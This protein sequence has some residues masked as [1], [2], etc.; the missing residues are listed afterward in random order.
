[1]EKT[2]SILIKNIDGSFNVFEYATYYRI[3]QA[4]NDISIIYLDPQN[5]HNENKKTI[6]LLG[7]VSIEISSKPI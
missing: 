7:I 6:P 2:F 1:M 3:M 5:Q 4:E